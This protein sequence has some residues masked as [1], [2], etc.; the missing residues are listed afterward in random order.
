MRDMQQQLTTTLE[1]K[2]IDTQKLQQSVDLQHEDLDRMQQLKQKV[3]IL[4]LVCVIFHL[5]LIVNKFSR[6]PFKALQFPC[7]R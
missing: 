5:L 3:F 2:Q 6:F 1:N 7:F 4:P